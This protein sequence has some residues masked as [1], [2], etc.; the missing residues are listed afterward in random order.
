MRLKDDFYQIIEHEGGQGDA[1]FLLELNGGHSIYTAHFPGHP[2]TPGVCILQMVKELLEEH[3]A[4]DLEIQSVKNVKFLSVISPDENPKVEFSLSHIVKENGGVKA[5]AV[6]ECDGRVFAKLSLQCRISVRARLRSRGICLVIPTYNNGRTLAQVVEDAMTYIS[7]IIVVNDGSTDDTAEIL[8]NYPFV[9]VVSYPANRGKGYSLKQGF[10]KALDMGFAYAITMDADGQHFAKDIPTFL[11]ANIKHPGAL[12]VGERNLE[13]VQRTKGSTFAN[14]FSNFWFAV[15]TGHCLRDT[16]TGYRLYPLKRLVGLNL[17]TSRYEAELELMVFASWHG[18]ELHSVPIDVYYPPQE[19][20]VSHF[21]P[22]KDFARISVL[23]T[24][25]CILAV[26]YALPLALLRL[27]DTILRTAYCLIFFITFSSLVITPETWLYMKI[28]KMTEKKRLVIH[29][30]IRFIARFVMIY[31]GIPGTKFKYRVADENCF[32][33]PKLI[34]CN[35]QSNFDLMCSLIF[36]HKVIFLTKDWV[37]NNPFFGFL[38]RSAEYLSVSE[39]LDTL[40]PR[41]QDLVARG[42]S[43]A[44]FP[45]GTRS[46][47]CSIGRFHQGAFHLA[48]Q[49]GLDVLPFTLYGAG[50][51]L[52][53]KGLYLRRGLIYIEV[54]ETIR[55]RELD[56][57]GTTLQQASIMRMSNKKRYNELSDKFEKD[58]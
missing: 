5:Q 38:I 32:D 21:R 48:E 20:R 46:E 4:L 57:K 53:K 54:C 6:V 12:I 44:V 49:L 1:K 52:P 27:L 13:G 55:R 45:E 7:D 23:N 36:T 9:T 42:Y 2:V 31:H 28:G 35:H 34:V 19:E 22:F 50:K 43:I 16:Q 37:W 14:K 39:G 26:V 15:Q 17:L 30:I 33:T 41:L 25:L 10:R 18:T 29:K 51:V 24:L 8:S 47:D 11:A 40:L 56:E 58:A 3:L